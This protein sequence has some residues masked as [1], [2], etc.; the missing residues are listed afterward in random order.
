MPTDRR[1]FLGTGALALAGVTAGVVATSSGC[2]SSSEPIGRAATS[3]G[4]AVNELGNNTVYAYF[5]VAH[6]LTLETVN[7]DVSCVPCVGAKAPS[8]TE[9]LCRAWISRGLAPSFNNGQVGSSDAI[10]AADFGT[11]SVYNPNTL[12][13]T[14]DA[15]PLQDLF[16]AVVL[17]SWVP[18]DGTA[19]AA[20]RGVFARPSLVLRAGDYLVFSIDH[21][22]VPGGVTVQAVLGYS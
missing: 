10:P 4:W 18:M 20:S 1:R 13:L 9:T 12:G 5:R 6:S 22:G 21:S 19:A 14:C 2:G 15:A 3:F 7:I 8:F 16:Y 17:K 11:I